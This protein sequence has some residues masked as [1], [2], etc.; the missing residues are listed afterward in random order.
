[1]PSKLKVK[2]RE[3]REA[4]EILTHLIGA[5]SVPRKFALAAF[6]AVLELALQTAN[7]ANKMLEQLSRCPGARLYNFIKIVNLLSFS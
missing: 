7:N 2:P 6:V 3:V 4:I 5:T 1:M